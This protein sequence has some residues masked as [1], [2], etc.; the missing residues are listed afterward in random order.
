MNSKNNYNKNVIIV[1]AGLSGLYAGFTLKKMGYNVKILEASN[2]VGGRMKRDKIQNNL[3]IDKGGQW[4]GENHYNLLKLTK[5]LNLEL[6]ETNFKGNGALIINKKIYYGKLAKKFYKSICFLNPNEIK[7]SNKIKTEYF[8][9]LKKFLKILKNIN[10]KKPWISKNSNYLDKITVQ[11]WLINNNA[12]IISY[13]FFNYLCTLSGTG[14]YNIWQ[15]SMLDLLYKSKISPQNNNPEK[16]LIK[17]CAGQIPKLLA[18][19]LK[20]KKNTPVDYIDHSNKNNII[21]TS[22]NK[23]FYCNYIII[24]IPVP[25]ISNINFNPCLP[26]IYNLSCQYSPMGS[27]IK[28]IIVYENA[29]WRDN[30]NN[31][32]SIGGELN[33]HFVDS[34][35]NEGK[36]GILTGFIS[37]NN[38]I[39]YSKI[40]FKKSKN[41]I[42]KNLINLWGKKA[43]NYKHFK[44]YNWNN[45]CWIK[46]GFTNF[47]TPGTWTIIKNNWYKNYGNIIWAG[48]ETSQKW[49]GY[50]EGA[51][52][53]AKKAVKQIKLLDKNNY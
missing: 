8:D 36:P 34:S 4:V 44:I 7:I 15:S 19:K 27:M 23:K 24:A 13:F 2:E 48:T 37:G 42:I 31:G 49:A 3:Y 35:N 11:D 30:N 53:S 12:N 5:Q 16:F 18:K 50:F 10:I 40:S 38:V 45:E 39:K 25:L 47:R 6:F 33:E 28:I 51:I 9:L 43:L 26:N 21:V 41:I 46:G 29:F 14:G 1:G 52:I 32:F 22:K 17:N 20:I